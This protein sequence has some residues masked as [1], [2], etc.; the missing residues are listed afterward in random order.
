[1]SNEVTR[2][3]ISDSDEFPSSILREELRARGERFPVELALAHE[4]LDLIAEAAR[5]SA[6]AARA[7]NLIREN[8]D[9][10]VMELKAR[11]ALIAGR[12]GDLA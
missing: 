1:M 9:D 5:T 7:Y 12:M 11:Q 3:S 2:Y 6:H 8:S 4:I 10:Q